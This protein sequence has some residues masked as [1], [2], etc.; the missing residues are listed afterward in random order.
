MKRCQVALLVAVFALRCGFTHPPVHVEHSAL[1]VTIHCESLGEY[2]SDIG[3]ILVV[4][5]ESGRIVWRVEPIGGSFQLHNFALVAG[6]NSR[7]LL[8]SWGHAET[9]VP[10]RGP[11]VLNRGTKYRVFVC[12]PS[13]L[14]RCGSSE[15]AL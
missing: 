5:S 12:A 7:D 4:E 9:I 1:G 2:P 15:F 13:G 10:Q 6:A 3:R 14:K 8:L 11:F